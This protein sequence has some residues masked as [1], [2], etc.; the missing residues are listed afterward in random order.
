MPRADYRCPDCDE[1]RRDHVYRMSEGAVLS[2]PTC[3]ACYS[4]MEWIP[5]ARF[6]AKSDGD[7]SLHG[8]QGFRKFSLDV[9]GR[10]VEIDS[11]HTLRRI[12]RES[13]QRFRNGEG[14]PI[15]VRGYSQDHSN[16]LQNTFGE[17]GQIGPQTYSS[18]ARPT[19]RLAVKR[20]AEEPTVPVGPGIAP[21]GATALKD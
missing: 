15:R 9:D 17:A 10:S 1:I 18:G 19:K 4:T 16:M 3:Q 7:A 14:E 12:E 5:A 6:D 21:S 13:E 11:L 2:A 20:H 8:E